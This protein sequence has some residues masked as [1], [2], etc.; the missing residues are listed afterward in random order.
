MVDFISTSP[1]RLIMIFI[2]NGVEKVLKVFKI[3]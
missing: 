1:F 2:L 3:N